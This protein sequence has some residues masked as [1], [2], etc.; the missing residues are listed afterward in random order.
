MSHR[1][2]VV[3]GGGAGRRRRRRRNGCAGPRWVWVMRPWRSL[4]PALLAALRAPRGLAP[5]WRWRPRSSRLVARPGHRAAA[6]HGHRARLARAAQASRRRGVPAARGRSACG[7]PPRR[8]AG[9]GRGGDAPATIGRP[10]SP[11]SERLVPAERPRDERRR[12][13]RRRACPGRGRVA[14]GCRRVAQGDSIAS[15]ATGYYVVLEARRH[16]ADGRVAVAGVLI[17]A[18]PAV[19]DRSRSLAEL[20]RAADRGRP[21]GLPAG[22][23]PRQ[24]PT[25]STTRSPRP[26][27]PGCSS[28]CGRSRRSRGRPRSSPTSAEAG[29]VTWLVL[30]TLALGLSVARRPARADR[31]SGGSRVAAGARAGR[32]RARTPAAVLACHL[33]PAAARSAVWLRRRARA[34]GHPADD[35]R[36]LALAPA[37]STTMVRS[38]ARQR[39]CCSRPRISSAASAAASH[40]RRMACRSAS[41]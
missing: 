38:G 23:R 4:L 8:A 11:R 32:P 5:P 26:P 35:R 2:S 10:R 22:H 36:R 14:T 27:A 41:G 34:R 1:G 19:P 12:A 25:C 24:S 31:P 20:F 18:H 21:R 29:L 17:W 3:G 15:R 39:C 28:A 30:L 16:T 33:L 40:R 13:R 6:P 7:L 9:R 37:A